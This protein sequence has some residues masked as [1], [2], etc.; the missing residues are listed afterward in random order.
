MS[1]QWVDRKRDWILLMGALRAPVWT[2]A[3]KEKLAQP[4]GDAGLVEIVGGHFHF[5][6]VTDS[7]AHPAFAHLSANGGK[8]EMF[9]VQFDAKHGS[10]QHRCD[11]AFDFNVLFF[12][13]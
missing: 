11:A 1:K 8:Y 3:R 12:H 13:G 4:P 5:H 7:E 2:M 6:A 9:V 10:G